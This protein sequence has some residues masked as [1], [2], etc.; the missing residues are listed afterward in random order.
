[1]SKATHKPFA[2]QIRPVSPDGSAQVYDLFSGGVREL[3]LKITNLP[4]VHTLNV[5][6]SVS[7]LLLFLNIFGEPLEHLCKQCLSFL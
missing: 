3:T 7:N 1:M 4:Y 5:K 6:N 2:R